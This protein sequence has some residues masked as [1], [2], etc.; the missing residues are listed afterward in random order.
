[1]SAPGARPWMGR[2][3]L[4]VVAALVMALVVSPAQAQAPAPPGGGSLMEQVVPGNPCPGPGAGPGRF[5]LSAYTIDYDEGGF[6]AVS[7]KAVGTL[8]EMTFAAARWG[9]SVGMWLIGWAFS[10]G[11]ADRLA[12]PMAAVAGRYRA[13]FFVPLVGSALLMS[14]AYGGLQIFRGRLGRGLGE[15]VLSLAFVALF[16]TWLLS[17][18]QGFFNGSFRLTAQLAG[19]VSNVALTD[20]GSGCRAPQGSFAVPRLDAAVAPLTAQIQESFVQ[21]PYELLEWGTPVPDAA[22]APGTRCWPPARAA[23]A[24]PWSLT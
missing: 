8:T 6:T 14:A 24:T 12:A 5:P 19:S 18:P 10:F 15:F 11:F 7:R 23:T 9:V 13:A 1:M 16:G 4:V 22:P 17:T 3:G 21:K 2:V 20:P